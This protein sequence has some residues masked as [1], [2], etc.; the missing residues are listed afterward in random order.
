MVL[1]VV[2]SYDSGND[3]VDHLG[4]L[5]QRKAGGNFLPLHPSHLNHFTPN[6][7]PGKQI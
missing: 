4:R 1:Y 2:M 3:I 6:A 5:R 7:Y